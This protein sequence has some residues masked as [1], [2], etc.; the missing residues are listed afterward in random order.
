M[1]SSWLDSCSETIWQALVNAYDMHPQNG[2]HIFVAKRLQ[3]EQENSFIS[4]C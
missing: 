2:T 1:A 4:I 3:R